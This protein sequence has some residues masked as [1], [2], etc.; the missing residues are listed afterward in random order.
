MLLETV[1]AI[2]SLIKCFIEIKKLKKGASGKLLWFRAPKPLWYGSLELEAY[3]RTNNA[4]E[5]Y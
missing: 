2:Y 3:I 1:G 5:I 4:R